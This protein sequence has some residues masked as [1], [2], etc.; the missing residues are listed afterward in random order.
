MDGELGWRERGRVG[1]RV[2]GGSHEQGGKE[3]WVGGRERVGGKEG[4]LAE[5]GKSDEVLRACACR[6]FRVNMP[7]FD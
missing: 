3:L 4:R 1:R 5:V 6:K 2:G 7:T